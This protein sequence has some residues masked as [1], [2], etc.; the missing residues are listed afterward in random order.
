MTRLRRLQ[1]SRVIHTK[2]AKRRCGL[3]VLRLLVAARASSVMILATAYQA[4]EEGSGL[5][6][7]TA[8]ARQL[9][10]HLATSAEF[11]VILSLAGW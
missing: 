8:E 9:A 3:P 1:L 7:G 11:S 6:G 10:G 2:S 5:D 4:A